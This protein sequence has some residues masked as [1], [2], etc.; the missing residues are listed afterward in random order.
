M[1]RESLFAIGLALLLQAGCEP[2]LPKGDQNSSHLRPSDLP[3]WADRQNWSENGRKYFVGRAT[4][5]HPLDEKNALD[6]ALDNAIQTIAKT[7]GST[8]KATTQWT[9]HE[10]GDPGLGDESRQHTRNVAGQLT[11]EGLVS[12]VQ[13]EKVYWDRIR[14][15]PFASFTYQYRYFV[16]VSVAEQDFNDLVDRIKKK[17]S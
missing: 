17:K 6:R 7:A 5:D 13:Q 8:V 14:D 16:L 9:Q 1:R 15:K 11:L 3:D 12:N 2:G 4:A 10:R